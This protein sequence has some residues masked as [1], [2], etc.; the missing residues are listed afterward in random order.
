MTSLTPSSHSKLGLPLLQFSKEH[1]PPNSPNL[2]AGAKIISASLTSVV[3]RIFLFTISSSFR[4]L[5]SLIYIFWMPLSMFPISPVIPL[6][7]LSAILS[8]PV[9]FMN[10]P[11]LLPTSS[12]TLFLFPDGFQDHAYMLSF[13]FYFSF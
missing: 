13:F 12:F 9:N 6:R 3:W 1:C 11:I 7:W 2:S 8:S 4:C 5:R 10:F